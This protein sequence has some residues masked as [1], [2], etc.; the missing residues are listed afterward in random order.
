MA[1]H[2]RLYE[3]QVQR[4][5]RMQQAF[6][7]MAAGRCPQFPPAQCPPAQPVLLTFEEFVAQNAG[8]SLGTGGSTVGGGLRSTPETRSPTTPIHGGG[9]GGG[10][11]L[12]GS[13]AAS[14]DDLGFGGLGGDNLRG[15]RRP[16]A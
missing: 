11:G 9:G 4:D 15:A 12:G 7:E 6:Q 2:Q 5:S 8:P 13:A 14:S 1:W 3:H 16:G 10:G